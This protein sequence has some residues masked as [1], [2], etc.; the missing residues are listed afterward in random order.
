MMSAKINFF[1]GKAQKMVKKFAEA[2][3]FAIFASSSLCWKPS[4]VGCLGR[5]IYI[6]GVTVRFGF[7]CVEFSQS[8]TI[9]QEQSNGNAPLGVL[10]TFLSRCS[11]HFY[12]WIVSYGMIIY[13]F[14]WGFQRCSFRLIGQCEKPHTVERVTVWLHVFVFMS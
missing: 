1:V 12:G 10:Y 8:S 13:T 4:W 11:I 2:K 5:H 3:T 9:S 6:K 7:D 14:T